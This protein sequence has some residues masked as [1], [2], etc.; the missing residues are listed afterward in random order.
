MFKMKYM[1]YD[2][3]CKVSRKC[4][5]IY[6]WQ[7]ADWLLLGDRGILVTG[8]DYKQASFKNMFDGHAVSIMARASHCI[9]VFVR[10]QT[11][12]LVHVIL[13]LFLL[14]SLPPSSSLSARPCPPPRNSPFLTQSWYESML[15]CGLEAL[16]QPHP[17]ELQ[18]KAIFLP[19]AC[20]HA[21]GYSDMARTDQMIWS[22]PPT[23][24]HNTSKTYQSQKTPLVSEFEGPALPLPPRSHYAAKTLSLLWGSPTTRPNAAPSRD[25]RL[26]L[27]IE[28]FWGIIS[29]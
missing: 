16:H 9:H 6:S 23:S 20:H 17:L 15:L 5:L 1:R 13:S 19:D 11:P 2:C 7:K 8:R 18:K 26:P 12:L 4:K 25:V 27:L 29:Y 3:T 22:L 24:T 28:V 14:L 21:L 10:S